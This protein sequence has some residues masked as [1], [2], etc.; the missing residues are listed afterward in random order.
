[1]SRVSIIA[2]VVFVALTA[3]GAGDADP[4]GATRPGGG[5]GV[6]APHPYH[7][8]RCH[9][10]IS[11]LSARA[12]RA[13]RNSKSENKILVVENE[14]L[15]ARNQ[16]LN[17]LEGENNGL[18]QALGFVRRSQFH[19]LPAR[20]IARKSSTWW[21]NVQI[22]R[23]EQDGLDTDMPVVTDLGLVGKTTTVGH[24][25]ALVLLVTDENCK[26]AAYVEGTKE[27]GIVSGER[28]QAGVQP[29][30]SL[31]LPLPQ[32]ANLQPGQK[33][34][35]SGVSGGVFPYNLLLG[36]IKDFQVRVARRPREP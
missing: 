6:G 19:L 14:K 24:D 26:V 28:S 34:F 3:P 5:A 23:G 2:L 29:D 27:K 20:I 30:L 36:T 25:T 15:R 4:R 17:D 31:D 8:Q 10:A 18:R 11:A 7:D 32:G 33:V 12:S 21:N 9:P 13:C 22:D 16:I 35:S 1:M